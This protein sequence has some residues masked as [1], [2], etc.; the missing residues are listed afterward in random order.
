MAYQIHKRQKKIP[1]SYWSEHEVRELKQKY[2]HRK[3]PP[4]LEITRVGTR[5]VMGVPQRVHREGT[6]VKYKEKPARVHK[7]TK[8]GLWIETFKEP[9][10][11]SILSPTGKIIFIPEKKVEHEIYPYATNIPVFWGTVPFQWE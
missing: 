4:F 10:D 7:V 6:M 1:E 8:R 2:P 5:K 11:K 9:D 3:Y